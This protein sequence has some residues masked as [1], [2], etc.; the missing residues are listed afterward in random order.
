MEATSFNEYSW[1]GFVA[2]SMTM[3]MGWQHTV[4]SLNMYIFMYIYKQY[5]KHNCTINISMIIYVLWYSCFNSAELIDKHC[6]LIRPLGMHGCTFLCSS[7]LLEHLAFVVYIRS[8]W[9][10]TRRVGLSSSAPCHTLPPYSRPWWFY[11]ANHQGKPWKQH[12]SMNSLAAA[13]VR[14]QRR[15]AWVDHT[16]SSLVLCIYIYIYINNI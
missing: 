4:S 6:A 15:C 5:L 3:C 13:L 11:F 8:G 7:P 1:W 2:I 9:H 10:P 14:Y 16:V 12:H